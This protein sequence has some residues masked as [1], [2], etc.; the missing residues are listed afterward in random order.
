MNSDDTRD[1]D[2]FDEPVSDEPD[3]FVEVEKTSDVE[4]TAAEADS[5]E[6]ADS[7]P[8]DEA[9][10]GESAD[11]SSASQTDESGDAGE[12]GETEKAG[13][14]AI[15]DGEHRHWRAS[16]V[17][18]VAVAALVGA[19]VC[20]GYFGY[21]G[22]RA[23]TVDADREQARAASVDAAEQAVINTFTVDG[24][25]VEEWQRRMRSS[26]TGDALKQAIDET[27]SGTVQQIQAA[28]AQGLTITTKVV[29][30]A[31]T[32]LDGDHATVLV[33]TL[34]TSSAAPDKPQPQSNLL[35]MDKVDGS[36]KASKIVPLTPIEYYE[37][38]T[39]AQQEQ[40][41]DQ[42]GGGN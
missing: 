22:I 17:L 24:K 38:S 33:M 16:M 1:P 25:S 4:K 10:E 2:S 18:A 29:R 41:G 6:D 11:E 26:L 37:D 40:S 39:G 35:S 8:S 20:L 7:A 31:A 9:P 19:V 3:A 36:W 14:E 27:S 21:T 13:S 23:Y 34:A 5:V 12:P 32:E 15:G 30:S 28:K 42:Q